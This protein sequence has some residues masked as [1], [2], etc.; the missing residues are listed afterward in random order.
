MTYILMYFG[1]LDRTGVE[2]FGI[3]NIFIN[4]QDGDT[5]VLNRD[6]YVD[7]VGKYQ[8]VGKEIFGTSYYLFEA[9]LESAL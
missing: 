1:R 4:I 8:I 6:Y 5:I 7:N 9:H 2:Q 3:I